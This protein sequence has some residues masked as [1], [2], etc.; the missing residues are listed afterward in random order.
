MLK[1]LPT[2]TNLEDTRRRWISL[3]RRRG[4]EASQNIYI[5]LE[6]EVLAT[7]IS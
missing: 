3:E 1:K 5:H 6:P 7:V 4:N 2:P